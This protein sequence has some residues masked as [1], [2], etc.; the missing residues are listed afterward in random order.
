M[1]ADEVVS[2]TRKVL[3]WLRYSRTRSFNAR[4]LFERLKGT[5][6]RMK[7]LEK[8]LGE[9]VEHGYVRPGVTPQRQGP[10]R[11]KSPTYE[12]NPE[13]LRQRRAA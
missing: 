3:S 12:V 10:G 1:G 4:D 9:L 11:K 5:L 13:F 7:R 6:K 2:D 8:A